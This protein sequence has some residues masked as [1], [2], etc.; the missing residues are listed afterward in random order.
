[1]D[2]YFSPMSC[3][4]ASRIALHEAGVE[5]RFHE[6]VLTTRRTRGGAD[7]LAINPMGQVPALVLEDGEVLT[8]GAAVLQYIADRAPEAGLAPPP[9]AMARTRLQQWLNYIAVEIHRTVFHPLFNPG[10]PPEAMAYARSVVGVR[11]D[12]VSRHL[13][14]REYLVGERFTVADAYLTTTL[15]WARAAGIDLAPWPVLGAYRKRMLARPA[16]ARAV[17]EE[18]ALFAPA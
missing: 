12:L 7:Y 16:V 9:G 6:V 17:S 13:E 10:P 15:M 14:G 1:M 11:Y 18:M 5:A 4:L 8:E 2:L 3:S